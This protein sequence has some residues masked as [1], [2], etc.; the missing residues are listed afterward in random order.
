M[1]KVLFF[2][3]IFSC[4]LNT[5]T[6]QTLPQVDPEQVGLDTHKLQQ[7]DDFILQAISNKEI[8]GAVLAVV[9]NGKMAYLKAYGNRQVYPTV[10]PMDVNTVFDMA[11][12]TKPM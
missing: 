3:S 6:A 4:F 1:N 7:A 5:A 11:S 12:C 10:V 8:P 9:R 2:L